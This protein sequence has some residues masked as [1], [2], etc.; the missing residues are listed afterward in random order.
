M[1]TDLS[2]PEQEPSGSP[3]GESDQPRRAL[4]KNQQM[5]IVAMGIALGGL[6]VAIVLVL[7]FSGQ[8]SAQVAGMYETPGDVSPTPSVT[9]TNTPTATPVLPLLVPDAVPTAEGL[10]WPPEPQLLET[11]NAPSN[12]LWWDAGYLY[13]RPVLLDVIAAKSPAGTWAEVLFSGQGELLEG[14]TL[15]NGDDLRVVVWDGDHWWEIPRSA[16]LRRTKPGW[17]ILFQIQDPSIARRGGYYLYFGNAFASPPPIAGDAPESSRLL[18]AFGERESGEWGPTVLWKA[19]TTATQTIVSPD[20][21]IVVSC[22]P[23]GLRHDVRVQLR[24]VPF[25]E[26]TK[27]WPLPEFELHADPP[28]EPPGWSNVIRWSPPLRITINWAGLPVDVQTLRDRTHFEYDVDR[29]TWYRIPIEFDER[30][31]LLRITTEQP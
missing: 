9:P 5:I 16:R 26:S 15:G 24:T 1:T 30:Q 6:L 2:R 17:E 29:G 4:T 22:P 11:P 13:R 21:R 12:L 10:Y 20:G 19:D 31:G 3:A 28:P 8:P 14:R 27:N 23:G 18:L 7:W 25:Q